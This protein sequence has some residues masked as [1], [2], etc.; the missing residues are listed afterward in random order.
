MTWLRL[1]SHDPCRQPFIRRTR[2]GTG[3]SMQPSNT[4]GPFQFL[5]GARVLALVLGAASAVVAVLVLYRLRHPSTSTLASAEGPPVVSAVSPYRNLGAD[6]EYVGDDAC[7]ECHAALAESYRQHPMARTLAPIEHEADTG[8]PGAVAE[9]NFEAQGYQFRVEHRGTHVFHQEQRRGPDGRILAEIKEEVSY[10]LGSGSHGRAYLV[11]RDGYL[12]QSPISWY[13]GGNQFALDPSA[14]AAFARRQFYRPVTTQCIFCHGNDARP[15][16]GTVNHFG[17]PLSH[18]LGV[19]CERCHGPGALHARERAA[20]M[21]VA[22]TDYTIVNPSHLEPPLRRAICQQCHLQGDVR[23]L[24]RGRGTF[25]YRPGLPLHDYWTVF[26]T[27]DKLKDNRKAVS[28]TEQMLASRCYQ[29]S[30]GRLGCV[31]CHDPHRLP[32]EG[33][34]AAFYRGR[35]LTCHTEHGCSL[36]PVGRSATRPADNCAACHMPSLESSNIAHA[37]VTDHRVLRKSDRGM[38]PEGVM[39]LLPGELPLALFRDG[40]D[41]PNDV[42]AKRDLGLGLIE[43][44]GRN[45]SGGPVPGGLDER[46]LG[47]LDESLGVWPDDVPALEARAYALGMTGRLTEARAAFEETLARAPRRETTLVYAAHVAQAAGLVEA[48]ITYWERAIAVNP[49]SWR[50]HHHLA[51]RL[52]EAKQWERATAAC[53]AALRLNPTNVDTRK[54]LIACLLRLGDPVKARSE[55]EAVLALEPLKRKEWQTWFTELTR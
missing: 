12:F 16:E 21:P 14:G 25:D 48:P 3:M 17:P 46:A 10:V 7:A 32:A 35:C 55:L 51:D 33:E 54:I 19:G 28:Q 44:L 15:T 24:P 49:W 23:V 36:S 26:V 13:A 42:S 6:V 11:S 27:P 34:K 4:P 39:A 5:R 18:G 2:L 45:W 22:G 47:L 52:A 53:A 20:G 41:A 9:G 43:W 40:H 8:P 29:E 37:A 38:R 30:S 50:Y 31:S 1:G